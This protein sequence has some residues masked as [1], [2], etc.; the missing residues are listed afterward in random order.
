M[1]ALYIKLFNV[2][3]DID[4]NCYKQ[5]IVFR[6]LSMILHIAN[7]KDQIFGVIIG[8][9]MFNLGLIY[10]W[11]EQCNNL[12]SRVFLRIVEEKLK[13]NFVQKTSCDMEIE[14]NFGM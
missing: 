5:A 11:L 3:L 4:S 7:V 14:T 10:M 9:A 12:D 13:S 1:Y 8:Q 6:K 2:Y